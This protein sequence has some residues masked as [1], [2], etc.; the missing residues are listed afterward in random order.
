[1]S[2]IDRLKSAATE[3]PESEN[4][5]EETGIVYQFSYR[6]ELSKLQQTARMAE[7]ESRLHRLETVLGA[8]DDKLIRLASGNKKGEKLSYCFFILVDS[9]VLESLLETAEHLAATASMLDSA[10]L[11]HIEG[12][13]SALLQN[14]DSIKEKRG[15]LEEDP[16][17]Q[18]MA[19]ITFLLKCSCMVYASNLSA[20]RSKKCSIF[21]YTYI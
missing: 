16:E 19:C 8:T 13:L 11:D 17:K 14:L 7:L 21:H 18:K 15:K 4:S 5:T 2:L 20:T 6:P 1:M 10:Q 12:R 3:Q 9:T